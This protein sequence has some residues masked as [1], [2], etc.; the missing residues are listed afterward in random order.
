MWKLRLKEIKLNSEQNNQSRRGRPRRDTRFKKGQ[1]GNP[2][3]RPKII[4]KE[5]DPGKSL[6]AVDS[7]LIAVK[8]DG[9]TVWITKAEVFIRQLFTRAIRGTSRHQEWS[10]RWRRNTSRPMR[11]GPTNRIQATT[12]AFQTKRNQLR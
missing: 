8:D 1:S 4:A 2:K 9:R 10:S 5:C 6:Q 12:R 11:K 7:E 3:G